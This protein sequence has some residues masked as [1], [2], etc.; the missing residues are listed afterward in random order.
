MLNTGVLGAGVRID[1]V[2][3]S[4]FGQNN[5][6][7]VN[8]DWEAHIGPAS[9]GLPEGQFIQT[10]VDSIAGYTR[11]APTRFRFVIGNQV[12]NQSY[13]FSG[14]H[15]FISDTTTASPYLSLVQQAVTS[16]MNLT[17]GLYAQIFL[18]TA[19]NRNSKIDFGQISLTVR[20]KM[21][22]IQVEID[23]KPGKEPNAI[24]PTSRQK[25]PVV[26]LTTEDFDATQIDPDTVTFGPDGATE[27]HRAGHVKDVDEDGD[28][29]LLLH[30]DTRD[31]GIAC[32]DT[33]ATLT[34]A[35]FI[36]EEISATDTIVTVNCP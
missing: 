23:I 3:V 36:G 28:M 1:S 18:W 22:V 10:L 5:G 6:D 35:T 9:F 2:E 13:Q 31:T 4:A 16:P 30:F 17:D 15:D 25:I 12:D 33:E 29:D 19:D 7:V 24:N 14:Q 27:F 20:G 8:F 34:G 11:I 21:P 32:A 26:V